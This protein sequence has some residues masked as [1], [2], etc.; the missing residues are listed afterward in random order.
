MAI[1]TNLQMSNGTD[2][3]NNLFAGNGTSSGNQTFNIIMANGVD[4]GKGWYNKSSCYAVYGNVG[5]Q[6]ASGNDVGNLLGKYGTLNCTCDVD[7][8]NCNDTDSDSDTDGCFV[9]GQL[10]TNRGMVD[11]SE[12]AVGDAVW[13]TDE[14]F[15]EVIAVCH[16]IVG[17]R[18]IYTLENGGVVTEDHVVFD[19]E[20]PYT[21]SLSTW[22]KTADKLL[23]DGDIRGHYSLATTP[24]EIIGATLYTTE[25]N[26]PTFSPICKGDSFIGYL[27]GNRVLVAGQV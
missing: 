13:G 10:L 16:N 7:V 12:I 9:Y 23:I 27:N 6:D 24:S 21:P 1:T 25:S 3:G 26:T 17:N 8:D 2:L 5:F 15:H 4:L 19:G 20:C 22:E 14:K 18:R 11:V